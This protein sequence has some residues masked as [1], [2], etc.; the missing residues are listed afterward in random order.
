MHGLWSNLFKPTSFEQETRALL[1]RTPIFV[2]L[3][4]RELD[5]IERI[6]YRRD[7]VTGEQ[8]FH[9]GDPG[10]GMYIIQ[11][12]V[13]SIVQMPDNHVLAELTVGD[14][15]GEIALLNE[16]PRSASAIALTECTL[17][18]LCQPD[19]LGLFKRNSK[20]GVKV[21]IPLSQIT[22][23]R[24]VEIDQE[25]LAMHHQIAKLEDENTR[26]ARQPHEHPGNDT[27][28]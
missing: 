18:G 5:S 3:S 28:D 24:L 7:Y 1:K 23:R 13:V 27:L 11:H 14:F 8:I 21:L 4:K 6:M 9:Q 19:L 25:L 26:L 15:F 22:G 16:T 2:A 20:L 12:G 10:I 17:L